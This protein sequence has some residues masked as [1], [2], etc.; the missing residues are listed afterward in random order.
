MNFLQ[1]TL[2]RWLF[3]GLPKLVKE[4]GGSIRDLSIQLDHAREENSRAREAA[5]EV[6]TEVWQAEAMR[7]SGPYMSPARLATQRSV[8]TERLK[9]TFWE[10]ELA[11]D[12]RGWQR[13]N[14]M[15]QYE[16]SRY[17]IQQIILA[18]RL[19]FI[20]NPLIRRGVMLTAYYV[21]ARGLEI[22]SEDVAANDVIQAFLSRND[23]IFGHTGMVELEQSRH[24][25]GNLF[26]AFFTNEST[27]EVDVRTIDPVEIMEVVTDPEDGSVEQYIHRQYSRMELDPSS[28][29]PKTTQ[30]DEWYPAL[31]YVETEGVQLLPAIQG[32]PV[33]MDVP[34]YHVKA[35]GLP[36]W[37]FGCPLVYAAIDWSKA[38]R[39][40]ME[41]FCTLAEAMARFSWN[42]ETKGDNQAV[43]AFTKTLATTLGDGG[44]S[45]ESNPAP[46]V[47]SVHVSGPG[48]VLNPI[49]TAGMIDD[50]DMCR[51]IG[52]MVSAA[53]DLPE[54]ML[55]GRADV[56]NLATAQTLDRPTELKFLF[57]QQ[58]WREYITK[59]LRY[60]LKRSSVAPS[61]KV[62][63]SAKIPTD[64]D[65]AVKFP[66][67]IEHSLTE[68][69]DSI[70]KACTLGNAQGEAKGVDLRVTVG[71]LLSELGFENINEL[72]DKMFPEATYE[73]D[74]TLE[75]PEP[76][77]T[78]M[79]QLTQAAEALREA[80]RK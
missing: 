26:F 3:P 74:R 49:K 34:V 1:R 67:V 29:N 18:S 44:T 46:N 50:P 68:M 69:V 60:A 24:T 79:Q 54:T 28:G 32:K 36:K 66:S 8:V 53:L 31:D 71:M 37:H 57:I 16:F 10:L 47:G 35:G 15:A 76:E 25:D 21:F 4:A 48:N 13:M 80:R 65:I 41:N 22:K 63:E 45:A 42:Y 5:L 73:P 11:L 58:S 61:G 75:P 30:V 20:K 9:E 14:A 39:K 78:P 62:K 59:I 2:G 7:G 56:G 6:A 77:P 52:Q 51:P 19:Y 64:I 55:F 17:G 70:V 33:R 12:N 72:L 27:G 43:A 40:L 38:Y 23:R